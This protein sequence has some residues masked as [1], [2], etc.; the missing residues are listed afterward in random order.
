VGVFVQFSML[1]IQYSSHQAQVSY[2][3][4]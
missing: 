1:T 3:G 4:L 2:N